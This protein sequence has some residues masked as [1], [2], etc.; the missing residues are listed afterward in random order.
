MAVFAE[1]QLVV[2][3]KLA[4]QH[5]EKEDAGDDVGDG[6]GHRHAGLKGLGP[7]L[8]TASRPEMPT[9]AKALSWLSQATVMEVKPT[10]PATPSY[11]VL[12]APEATINPTM[13]LMAPERNMVRIIT[14]PRS[15]PR[16]GRC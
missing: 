14:G 2:D 13:P 12:L 7:L 6:G 4:P 3:E 8:K 5:T 9:M 1:D 16:T 10:P 15:C 11:S